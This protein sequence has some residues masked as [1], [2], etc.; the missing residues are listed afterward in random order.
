VRRLCN[1]NVLLVLR[2]NDNGLKAQICIS[3]FKQNVVQHWFGKKLAD[4]VIGLL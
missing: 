2:T 3:A 4:E 1:L